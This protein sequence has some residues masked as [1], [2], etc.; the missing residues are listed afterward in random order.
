M[1]FSIVRTDK[2]KVQHLTVKSA[3]WFLERIQTDTKAGDIA[4]LREYFARNGAMEGYEL[5][6]PVARIYPSVELAKSENGNL[7][8]VAMN[9]LVVLHVGSLMRKE[10]VEA[11]KEA[12]MT[13]P[14][15][16]AAFMG[17]DGRSV[18]ILVSVTRKDSA[19]LPRTES[20]MD[21][22]CQAAYEAAF[23][24]YSGLLPKPIERQTVSARSSFLM[25]LDAK[26]YY[27][28]QATPLQVS[29]SLGHQDAT[30]AEVEELREFDQQ[31]YATYE[32]MYRRAAEV[33]Y[34]ETADVIESQRYDAYIDRKSVV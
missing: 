17:A 24:A 29:L 16:F 22:F 15:T 6:T 20:E 27:N 21:L 10:D 33:A 4:G 26:P 32:L 11:V 25:T 7:E 34:E 30:D 1:R 14:T 18:E 19:A 8:I 3:E 2:K 31:L 13:L 28:D 23:G 12:S 5:R 9:G